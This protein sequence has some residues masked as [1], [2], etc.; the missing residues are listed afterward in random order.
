MSGSGGGTVI[1]G[2][3]PGEKAKGFLE[4]L[5][6]IEQYYAAESQGA[7][8]HER[9]FTTKERLEFFNVGLKSAL[10]SGIVSVVLTPVALGVVEQ[11]VPIFGAGTS[12]SGFDKGFAFSIALAISFGYAL[13]VSSVARCYKGSITKLMVK[14]LLQ[15]VYVGAIVKAVVAVILYHSIAFSLLTPKLLQVVLIP[16]QKIIPYE[17]CS[18]IYS[19]LLAFKPILIQSSF[20]IVATSMLYVMIPQS[21]IWYVQWKTRKESENKL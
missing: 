20:Y 7:E 8:V 19:W 11:M 16:A 17:Y 12:P 6:E 5:A 4:A 10:V 1:L 2:G 13:F 21:T 15:G 3:G 9:F 14:M 18:A